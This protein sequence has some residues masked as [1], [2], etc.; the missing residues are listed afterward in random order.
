[1]WEK[2]SNRNAK[3]VGWHDGRTTLQGHCFAA[4]DGASRNNPHGPTGYGFRITSHPYAD[5]LVRGYMNHGS[6][7]MEYEALLEG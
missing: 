4:S 2:D 3:Y 5:E 1:M 6:N 7:E